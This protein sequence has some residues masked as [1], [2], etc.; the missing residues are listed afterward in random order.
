MET[1]ITRADTQAALIALA[2]RDE[3]MAAER[4]QRDGK[5]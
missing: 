4:E 1:T 5:V 2:E 3:K